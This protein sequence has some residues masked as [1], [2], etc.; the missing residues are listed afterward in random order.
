MTRRFANEPLCP[1]CHSPV[2]SS[3]P[4]IKRHADTAGN[5]PCPG[6]GM[7]YRCAVTDHLTPPQGGG[8]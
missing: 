2:E 1:V 7:P 6:T 8:A 4:V 5:D 3:T